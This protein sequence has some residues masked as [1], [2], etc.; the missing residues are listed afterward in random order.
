MRCRCYTENLVIALQ[1]S[2]AVCSIHRGRRLICKSLAFTCWVILKL[3]AQLRQEI[4]TV[5]LQSKSLKASWL[6]WWGTFTLETN[7]LYSQF[8]SKF[9][10]R[11]ASVSTSTN[12][13]Y[14]PT[15]STG[16]LA[17]SAT[18]HHPVG[19]FTSFHP[20][21]KLLRDWSLTKIMA[22]QVI[23]EHVSELNKTWRLYSKTPRQSWFWGFV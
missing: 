17:T 1:V 14:W 22:Q 6:Q 20:D 15:Q 3:W 10:D 9:Y 11:S 19:D 18:S 8:V 7:S 13:C 4:K 12:I 16:P 2:T 5:C 23:C 21:W